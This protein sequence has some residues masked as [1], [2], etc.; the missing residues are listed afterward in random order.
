MQPTKCSIFDVVIVSNFNIKTISTIVYI[1]Y[2]SIKTSHPEYRKNF[3][4]EKSPHSCDSHCTH[5]LPTLYFKIVD[6]WYLGT[7]QNGI[8]FELLTAN[9]Y[10][11]QRTHPTC[12]YNV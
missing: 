12:I 6:V 2:I 11:N 9:T 8:I 1:T 7:N 3:S 5:R 4:R 10:M